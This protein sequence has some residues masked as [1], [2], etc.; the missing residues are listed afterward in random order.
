MA[1]LSIFG[2][3]FAISNALIYFPKYKNEIKANFD[4]NFDSFLYQIFLI[5]QLPAVV[6]HFNFDKNLRL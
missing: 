2:Q 4:F 5:M 3:L 1:G 6:L